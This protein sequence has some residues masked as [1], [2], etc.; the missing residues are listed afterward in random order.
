MANQ[1]IIIQL[2]ENLISNGVGRWTRQETEEVDKWRKLCRDLVG[3][4]KEEKEKR[5]HIQKQS[6]NNKLLQAL[7]KDM[8]NIDKDR[9]P[10]LQNN[11]K[12]NEENSPQSDNTE[13][14]LVEAIGKFIEDSLED[15]MFE[16][17]DDDDEVPVV[18][19]FNHDRVSE[20]QQVS[21]K[22]YNPYEDD[23]DLVRPANHFPSDQTFK[24]GDDLRLSQNALVYGS[25]VEKS[26]LRLH[27]QPPN[28]EGSLR[29]EN[30]NLIYGSMV[31]K[32][33]AYSHLP[34]PP[35]AGIG[36]QDS[37][38]DSY[39]MKP[40]G[41]VPLFSLAPVKRPDNEDSDVIRV[42]IS[43]GSQV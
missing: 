21:K 17:E 39:Y 8:N 29:L 26:A 30:N 22:Q 33:A 28:L 37:I 42:D 43:E 36:A 32:H 18:V 6:E 38:E 40:D 11:Q 1:N 2:L 16:H 20:D 15:L 41:D 12:E 5:R 27:Q 34:M 9:K 14:K 7:K 35:K 4:L 25:M 24:G 10:D 31:Q 23:Q 13:F 19:R 3:Q